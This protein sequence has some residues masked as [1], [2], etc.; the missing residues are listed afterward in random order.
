[1]KAIKTKVI[2]SGIRSKVDRSLGISLSTP[3]LTTEERS[4]FMELQSVE[5]MALFEPI[6]EKVNL[7]EIKGEVST[8]TQ[9]QRMRAVIFLLW[10]QENENGTFEE[11]YR[12]KTEQIIDWLKQKLL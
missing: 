5:C 8:K 4:E 11:F 12:L 2:I 10:K 6:S 1:M 3:E 9:S 7:L